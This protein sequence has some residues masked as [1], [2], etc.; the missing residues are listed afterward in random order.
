MLLLH[1]LP[2]TL[3]LC[4][5]YNAGAKS[6]QCVCGWTCISH[7]LVMG[8]TVLQYCTKFIKFVGKLIQVWRSKRNFAMALSLSDS[9]LFPIAHETPE[10]LNANMTFKIPVLHEIRACSRPSIYKNG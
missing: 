5:C 6:V 2:A 3:D 8:D 7:G 4:L 9:F 1:H 10:P